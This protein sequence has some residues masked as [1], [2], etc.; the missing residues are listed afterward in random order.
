MSDNDN[1]VKPDVSLDVSSDSVNELEEAKQGLR[2]L[3]ARKKLDKRDAEKKLRAIEKLPDNLV[4]D[5]D[6]QIDVAKKHIIGLN[7]EIA[8]AGE[9]LKNLD[10]S[11]EEQKQEDIEISLGIVAS[12]WLK[13]HANAAYIIKD[14]EFV[15]IEEFS[16][17]P[18]KQNVQVCVHEP[19]R[20]V[21][22]LANDLKL[23]SWHLPPVRVKHL[24]SEMNRTFQISRY[25]VDPLLWRSDAVYLPIQHMESYFINQA[26]L[27]LNDKAADCI[28]YFDWLMYSLG[29]NNA[30][31]IEHI[32]RWIVHKVLNYRKAVTTPDL[33]IV[34]HVGGNGKGILQAIIRQMFPSVLSGKANSKTLNGNFNAIMM[35]KL[36]VFFDDQNSKEIPL[37]VVKQLAGSETM[38]FEPKGKDQ[39]EGEK[40]HS[41][42]WFSNELP[43]KLTPSGQEGGVDR[44]FSVMRTSITF[45]ESIRHH[46]LNNTD[47]NPMT[48]EE[49]KDIA[50]FVVSEYLL[51]RQCIA[52]WFKHLRSKYPDI[53]Q[54]YTLK[55]LHGT[56]YQYFLH[57]QQSSI[58]VIWRD[59]VQPQIE[60]GGC[61][62]VFVIRE[63]VRHM[64]GRDVGYRALNK[65]IADI[66][67]KSRTEITSERVRI[68]IEPSANGK[69]HQ[70]EVIR[71]R[72]HKQWIERSFDWSLVSSAEFRKTGKNEEVIPE[73]HLIFGIEADD[74]PDNDGDQLPTNSEPSVSDA[75]TAPQL[76]QLASKL[77]AKD[78]Q[79]QRVLDVREKLKQG[80]FK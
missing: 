11:N 33:V 46:N 30:E 67:A 65:I 74:R 45:L 42:A 6:A 68:E 56:D 49:S 63:L 12:K 60:R 71:P 17:S 28:V 48:V 76:D 26:S 80:L 64:E 41:S 1:T 25:S 61:V 20:F 73:E 3:I 22:R 23:K 58:D 44:R 5:K 54:N 43:F 36:I 69:P 79:E 55:A 14:D 8:S 53:N 72:D 18:E 21:E 57:K 75:A 29:G 35:G 15:T 19:S 50:E 9:E 77:P 24:F 40:T 32:E 13:S 39:Y 62:P 66:A 31:N 27:P 2:N 59:L 51:N 78:A 52:A 37:E 4:K 47:E 70:C 16:T 34:G 10:K 38:I 7:E